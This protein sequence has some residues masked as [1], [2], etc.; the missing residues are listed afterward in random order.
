[1]S[2]N[3]T[4]QLPVLVK[5]NFFGP[6]DLSKSTISG[7][8]TSQT[9]PS[10]TVWRREAR[11]DNGVAD[12]S[13]A[14]ESVNKTAKQKLRRMFEKEE[15]EEEVEEERERDEREVPRCEGFMAGGESIFSLSFRD[16]GFLL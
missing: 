12:E 16:L 14:S 6:S 11:L 9:S 7:P 2:T 1:M 13:A 15:V 3:P 8:M 5:E 4:W 10:V